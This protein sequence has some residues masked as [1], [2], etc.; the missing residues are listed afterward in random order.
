MIRSPFIA[1]LILLLLSLQA[2]AE[3]QRILVVGDSLSAAYGMAQEEGWVS[4]LQQRLRDKGKDFVVINAS[5]TG[6]TTRGALA[7]LP[8][9][10][11]R[12]QPNLV[13]IELGGNDGLRG[14]RPADLRENL[15]K[16]VDLSRAQGAQ[17]LLLGVQLPANYGPTY[18]RKF[19][20]VYAEVA[21]STQSALV[22]FFL[23]GVAENL[24]L[25]QADGIHPAAQAQARILDNVWP[26]LLPLLQAPD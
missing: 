12:H 24:A 19:H 11:Q 5:I 25:M 21:E 9:A 13:I 3:P 2:L 17:V 8:A 23:E 26:S 15:R 1:G 20:A 22:P 7:R 16:L 18:R 4:L 14:F 10:L 6:D